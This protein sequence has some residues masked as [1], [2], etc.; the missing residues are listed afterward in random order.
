MPKVSEAFIQKFTVAVLAIAFV[1]IVWHSQVN[2]RYFYGIVYGER[3][4]GAAKASMAL[5]TRMSKKPSVDEAMTDHC[6]IVT[7]LGWKVVSV[8]VSSAEE[9][10]ES[11]GAA[12]ADRPTKSPYLSLVDAKRRPLRL[13]Y[14]DLPRSILEEQRGLLLT[15][16]RMKDV[17]LVDSW[18]EK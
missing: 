8:E 13:Y 9:Y 16:A 17:K 14:F 2:K 6:K 7:G 10:Q 1:T 15:G 3:S 11:F 5:V 12:F 18:K 4:V